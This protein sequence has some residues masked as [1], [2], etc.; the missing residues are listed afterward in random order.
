MDP[1]V[2]YNC[3]ELRPLVDKGV[4]QILNPNADASKE[5]EPLELHIVAL[6]EQTRKGLTTYS[7][8]VLRD[9]DVAAEK[10][11]AHEPGH[12]PWLKYTVEAEKEDDA[13]EFVEE[14]DDVDDLIAWMEEEIERRA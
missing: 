11:A 12:G 10:A 3:E 14:F 6:R 1:L 4:L 2:A 9:A 13:T 7:V 5:W 8:Q